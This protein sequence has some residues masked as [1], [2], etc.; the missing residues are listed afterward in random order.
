MAAP[1][2][3]SWLLDLLMDVRFGWR[4]LR[5]SPGFAL[6]AILTLALGIGAN[7]AMFSVADGLMLRPPPFDHAERLYWVYDVNSS[8][9]LT[10]AD[11][12]PD[13]PGN[14]VY[15]RRHN[16]AFDYMVAWRN[17]FFSVAGGGH[18]VIAE[19]VRGVTVSPRFFDMLGVRAAIGRTFHPDE[20]EPGR[21]RVVVLTDG[22]WRRHFGGDPAIVGHIVLVD[23]S[24]VTVVGVLPKDFFFLFHDSAIF[25]PMTATAEF[26]S[27]R[28]THSIGVLARLAPGAM[29][30]EA[31]ADLERLCRD[32][33]R[34]Y[35]DTNEGW[36]AA[37]A[38][39]FPLNRNLRPALLMLLGAVACVLLIACINVGNLLL[40]RAGSRQREMTVRTALGASQGRL[41]RQMLAESAL[42]ATIGA[43]I[44]VPLA[45]G[46]LRAVWPFIPEVRI[47]GAGAIAIDT[48][49]LVVTLAAT[50]ITAVALGTLPALQARRTDHL[51]LS[52]GSSQRVTA[53]AALLTIEVAL[54]LMLLV[55]ATLLIKSLW[56]L[57]RLDLGFRPDRMTTMQVWLPESKYSDPG[58]ISRFH[59]E[60]LRRVQQ[61]HGVSAAAVVNTRPFLGWAL[62]ARLQMPGNAPRPDDPIVDF[63]VIS[64]GY[65]AALRAALARGRSLNDGDGPAAAPVALINST[66]L[67]RYW[68]TGD[69]IGKTIRL[70]LL[71][72][73][74][75]APW[76]PEQKADTYTIVGVVRDIEESRLG[77][78][79][80]P[81]VYLSYLQNPSRYGHLLV[82]IE[83]P[84]VNVLETVQRELRAIDPD[85]GL[86]DVQSMESVLDQ[87]VASP[88]LNSIL[89]W[90]FAVTALMLCAVGVYGVT[91]YVVARRTREFAI[92]LAIGARPAEIFR[93]VTREGA[94]IALVGIAIG[95][96]G[97]LLLARTLASLVF[98][99]TA[100]DHRTLIV[101]AAVVFAVAIL[102]CWRPAWHATRVDP[103]TVLRAE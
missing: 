72:S 87:A 71:G 24:P 83:G 42:L 19:Q 78:R 84:P 26:E 8:L 11:A 20:E 28:D 3:A 61:V 76:W 60:L 23:G 14:F 29:R 86:Y 74:I 13:S 94:T 27:R 25:V 88:R 62:G 66:M 7:T 4:M 43:V 10:V 9:H 103:V 22:F 30:S 67:H 21:D 31:Q 92:R 47:A 15:W 81:V 49:V 98:G 85:L 101:S 5:R 82:R 65:F 70:R 58:A 40:V 69:A 44:G 48:R 102:A 55:G 6:A 73:T 41:I 57:Q 77:D 32:L 37:I 97:A 18:E 80:R 52:P 17:W 91:S 2:R 38:P 33:E 100:T 96:G 95:V 54:S 35:P 93:T 16:L 89:L 53:G 63:R 56:N 79:V 1:M 34:V 68:P 36:S 59:Q 51:R 12:V 99:V 39:V 75:S 64:P 50:C 45:A 46:A 90:V